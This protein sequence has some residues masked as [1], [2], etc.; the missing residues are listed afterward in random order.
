[1]DH[2]KNTEIIPSIKSDHCAVT[3]EFQE[4]ETRVSGKGYWKINSSILDEE[5]YIKQLQANK[6]KWLEEFKDIED[7]RMIWELFKYKI[8]QFSMRYSKNRASV[9]KDNENKLE[10]ESLRLHKELDQET[11]NHVRLVIERKIYQVNEK[12]KEGDK[13]KTDGAIFRSKCQWHENGEKSSNFFLF[14]EKNNYSKKNMIK[15]QKR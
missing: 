5:E 9:Q 11:D 7:P 15:L 3:L 13:V 1:M 10:K 2:I 14:L 6:I 4:V 12:L 8:R